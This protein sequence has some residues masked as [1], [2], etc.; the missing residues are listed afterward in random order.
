MATLALLRHGQSQWNLENRFTGWIDV[1]L[2]E[3]GKAEARQ[4]GI[5]MKIAGLRFDLTFTSVLQRASRTLDLALEEMDQLGLQ[6]ERDQA[7]NERHYGDLQGFNKTDTAKKFGEE[8]VKIWRR[9]Y[10]IA[11]PGGESLENTAQRTLPYLKKTILPQVLAGHH[12]LV[13]AHGNSLRSIIM[14]LDT[15]NPNEVVNLE[16]GTGVPMIYDIDD[17]GKVVSKTILE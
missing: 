1:P 14:H 16:I 13:A 12:V 17:Q 11:P 2:T 15:L 4:A 5:K 6:I 7:L 10:D 8:Q 3:K 9:S